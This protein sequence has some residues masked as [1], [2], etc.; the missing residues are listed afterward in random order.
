M[1]TLCALNSD[2]GILVFH[3][4]REEGAMLVTVR[5]R[6]Q[7]TYGDHFRRC[8][9]VN[10]SNVRGLSSSLPLPKISIRQDARFVVEMFCFVSVETLLESAL[11]RVRERLAGWVLWSRRGFRASRRSELRRRRY[12][13]VHHG[14]PVPAGE[15]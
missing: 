12:L 13:R 7:Y 15:V 11:A 2:Y 10:Q 6:R 4:S 5:S 9:K 14:T 3:V 1:G 8:L